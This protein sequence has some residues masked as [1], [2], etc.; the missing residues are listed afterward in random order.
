MKR[1]TQNNIKDTAYTF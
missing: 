1:H